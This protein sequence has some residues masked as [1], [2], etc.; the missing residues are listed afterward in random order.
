MI[1]LKPLQAFRGKVQA[2]PK[3]YKQAAVVGVFAVVGVVALAITRAAGGIVATEP[4]SAALS[5][6]V[7]IGCDNTASGGKYLQF[8]GTA[9]T[10]CSSSG[11]GT[12][13]GFITNL[14]TDPSA[15]YSLPTVN[16]PAYNQP[17]VDATFHTKITRIA[18]DAGTGFTFTGG[19]SGTWG[20]DVRH[21]YQKDQPWSSDSSMIALQNQSGGNPSN[22]F[23]DGNTYQP[24]KSCSISGDDRWHPSP[25]HPHERIVVNGTSLYWMDVTTCAKTKTMTLP[26]N[27]HGFGQGEGN[28]SND[29]RYAVLSDTGTNM[30]YAV[31]MDGNKVGPGLSLS[32][33][34]LTDCATDWVSVSPS[35][36]YAVVAYTGD[37]LRAYNIDP[38]TL[39]I[40]SRPQTAGAPECSGHDPA[41]G[42]IWDLGHADMTLENGEDVIV[43]QRRGWCT[44][45]NGVTLGQV[46]KV[47]I[48]DDSVTS[49][50]DPSNEA[51]A[52]HIST[53]NLDFQG[54]VY[55]TYYDASGKRFNNEVVAVKL[56]G[57]KQVMRLA[58]THS[59]HAVY[60]AEE[61]AVPS[62]DGRRVIFASDWALA[63]GT[64]CG[65]SSNPQAYVIDA[66][67]G[68]TA[69]A[70]SNQNHVL[71][72]AV[73]ALRSTGSKVARLSR[74]VFSHVKSFSTHTAGTLSRL[75]KPATVEAATTPVSSSAPCV[76]NPPP[77]QWKHVVV[78]I[79][80]NRSWSSVIGNPDASYITSLAN[81]CSTSKNWLDA[82]YKAPGVKD[83]SYNSKP[84]YATYT[85]GLSPTEHG[86]TDDSYSTKTSVDN[87]F[88]Q[89]RNAGKTGKVYFDASGPN[90]TTRFT[91][92]YHDPLRY[93]NGDNGADAAYCL[94]NDVPLSNF[95]NDV[96]NNTL[97]DFS[98][99]IPTNCENMHSCSSVSNTTLN[100]DNWARGFVPQILDS[101]RYKS[102]DTA[103]F[104]VWDE[105]TPI[106]NVLV[107]PSVKPGSLAPSTSHFGALRTWLEM[108][109]LPM[110]GHTGDSVHAAED[111]LAVMN[112]G[113]TPA[114][115]DTTPPATS[116][117][118]PADGATVSGTTP[119]TATAS[120]NVGVSKIELY[121]NGTLKNTV[122]S[123]SLSYNWDTTTV[124]NGSY[125]LQTKAYDAANNVG[126]SAIRTITVSNAAA[127]TCPAPP[128]STIGTATINITADI[129]G[130]Y[131]VWSRIMAPD[132]NNNSYYIKVD[133]GCA[134]KVGDVAIAAN[135]WTWV[136]Y[137]D[138]Q[139]GSK[140][141]IDLTAGNHTVQL[142]GVEPGVKV[143][144][145]IFSTNTSCTPTGTGDNCSNQ[146]PADTTPPSVPTGLASPSQTTNSIAITW[147]ASTDNVGVAGYKIYRNGALVGSVAAP[148]FTDTGLAASTTYAYTVAAYDLAGNA[149][150]QS[151]PVN[152]TTKAPADTIA[153][154][155]PTGLTSPTQTT[156][157]I[158]LSWTA[159][160]DNVAV[161]GYR[162]FRNG[163]IV[164]TTTGTTFTDANLLPST[165]YTYAVAAYDAAGNFSPQSGSLSISTQ[166]PV[167][168][169]PPAIP[170]NVTATA[171]SSTQV[172]V[173]WTAATDN[174]G[175][176]NYYLI[177]N[178][179]TL[180][181]LGNVTSYS[182]TT[183]LPSTTYSY[184]VM[185]A[186]AA[187]NL[188]PPSTAASVTTPNT[189]DT[190]APS[191]PANL[192]A[193]AESPS[194]VN[195]SWQP[196]TD[197]VGIAGYDVYRA[198]GGGTANK[199][200]GISASST[201][202]GDASVSPNT[203]YSYF[204][205]A[206]DSSGNVSAH[207]NTV[208][209][210]TP[211]LPDTTP[212]SAPTNLHAS[213]PTINK[214]DLSWTAATDNVGVTKYYV[215]RD[216]ITIATLD[217]V[218][219]YTD[220]T[221]APSTSYT[222]YLMA[223]DEAGNVSAPS[224]T[225]A[226]NTPSLA[227]TT[228]PTTPTNLTATAASETQVNLIW[229][230]ASDN[231]GVV[232]Y[233]I[234]RD[235]T[236][237]ATV[238]TTSYGDATVAAGSTYKY[239]VKAYDAAGNIGAS[240]NEATVTTP[241]S[242]GTTQTLTFPVAAD[243]R[244]RYGSPNS[245]YGTD[246]HIWVDGS[247]VSDG[248]LK[249]NVSGLAGRQVVSAQ[250]KLRCDD[251]SSF[252]GAF[253]RVTDSNWDERKVT[254]NTAPATDPFAF[255][256][257][258]A[259]KKGTWVT[260]DVTSLITGDGTFSIRTNTALSNGSGYLSK[261]KS[262]TYA[263]RLYV[264][265]K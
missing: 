133:N 196:S 111:L 110:I 176:T 122:N 108:L 56:D 2:N 37:H 209:V 165:S 161:T 241:T 137:K 205:A 193:H 95:M 212:P 173:T 121:I 175:V 177:R 119:V 132:T 8:G 24:L 233:Y 98:V 75:W 28:P 242:S 249:F 62:R 74:S 228:P 115:A 202:Y 190:T 20:S 174:V 16:K 167:D 52:H 204:V 57:S 163:A 99:I 265:V 44:S 162:I 244:L 4:E 6:N 158:S 147:N 55:V 234:Y 106:P 232:G 164:T 15:V 188:S 61:H 63:C 65:T 139:T 136:D 225:I 182:D 192:L 240:S 239:I 186:D 257:L 112:G 170:T 105:D 168:T 197:N 41:A 87:I 181:V 67:A 29:G 154:T 148:S 114:P 40:S 80:E 145:V 47:R 208:D 3:A 222:Y 77:A 42:Y 157:S 245:N 10:S 134:Y 226:V 93:F 32:N 153:P 33:C 70:K 89:L 140:V 235:G 159:S 151:G 7:S 91:G 200:A 36:K 171:T 127:P 103:F 155:T 156:T 152:V 100:G 179:V 90:C 187:N 214:V 85:S 19:G 124:Q 143:D 220:D 125:T 195:L 50:T 17:F 261:E 252:G 189:P 243:T 43:G 31:D 256:S 14:V 255:T 180:A 184:T 146:A 88:R 72:V 116:I 107:A 206:R 178:G 68:A 216:G 223:A 194:Q 53:R 96:N 123:S 253:Y 149:S 73:N 120:D 135:A 9:D 224:N 54:W 5:G 213:A 23:L 259:V 129:T 236:K 46:V 248:L 22:I 109:N 11:G 131:R 45:L 83:G 221:L 48:S 201:S 71:A 144:R 51:Q 117:T 84:N 251:S 30:M 258:G 138:G 94:T 231:V 199:V 79:F 172:N 237:I 227:D 264:T 218:T 169:T 262:S 263:P 183:V 191:A 49:L 217:S 34:G 69:A 92:D 250:L 1:N 203:S 86:L 35:G 254:W 76:G 141:D 82:N 26:F 126:V 59:D 25:S 185:A 150:A 38:A 118:A 246:D 142:M 260:V 113:G 130:T 198:T 215:V 160:T 18:G 238:T 128:A 247:P 97:P 104:F 229:S 39:A 78:L 207:S 211:A 166:T 64:A 58:H 27:A 219:T 81:S 13:T 66:R 60:R 230:G 102:G 210:T 12:T 21:H 101:A